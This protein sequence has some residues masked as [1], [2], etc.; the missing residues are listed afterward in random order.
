MST[1]YGVVIVPEPSFT[2]RVYRARQ[3]ICGQ[4][5]SWAAEMH[6]LHLPLTGYFPCPDEAV[7]AV[8][9]GLE[10]VARQSQQREPGFALVHRRVATHPELP[11]H[12]FLEFTPPQGPV[13][14][15]SENLTVLRSEVL[16]VL[17]QFPEADPGPP[18]SPEGYRPRIYLM[19]HAK[20]PPAVFEGAVEFARAVVGDLSIPDTTRAWQL[21]LLRFQSA[22]AGE[23]WSGGGWAAD[24]SWNIISAHSL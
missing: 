14:K 4:Y 3:L 16:A 18:T 9:A 23:D 7:P 8:V 6:L 19:Q 5:A 11:G 1:R 2:A 22:A 15:T 12:I 20:L 13:R 17:D 10:R 21:L 24:L